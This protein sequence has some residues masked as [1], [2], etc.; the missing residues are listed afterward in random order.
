MTDLLSLT[1]PELTAFMQDQFGQPPFRARQ[2]WKWLWAKRARSFSEMSDLT[3]CLRAE[4]EA[5]ARISRPEILERRVSD[6]GTVKFL[7]GLEDGCRVETVLIPAESRDGKIRLTQCLSCQVG[8]PM[9]CTFCS[10]GAMGFTR[11]MTMAEI[12]GQLL[13]AQ[14]YLDDKKHDPKLRNLVFMGMG[15][16]L[17]N[18]KELLRALKTLNSDEGLSFSPRRITVSTCG[19]AEGLEELGQSGL[20]YLAV[21][22]HAPTQELRARIMPGA[23]RLHL[24][25]LMKLLKDY[26]LR[27]RERLTFEYLLLGGVNDS[28][29]EAR[30][31]AR[32]MS[33]IKGKLNLII[34]NP[35]EGLPYEEPAPESVAAFEALL[36]G[37]KITATVRKSKG[38]DIGAACG[39][40]LAARPR[41]AGQIAQAG[42]KTCTGP[43]PPAPRA[44]QP[45]QAGNA[46]SPGEE[47]PG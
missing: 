5:S 41:R 17:L 23:A 28:P 7:L 30:A 12:L 45:P 35:A 18:L 36:H 13:V 3:L 33:R 29:D 32:L 26:P 15:E 11:N 2:I 4:L 40:L 8:C 20:A 37:K 6:D 16:P 1:L 22:L 43:L 14:E 34:Y 25:D 24:D 9:G 10:T 39:Q 19:L 44:G 27:P 46:P 42:H 47:G 38:R 21:S 31:L